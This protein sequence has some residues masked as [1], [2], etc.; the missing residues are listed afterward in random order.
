MAENFNEQELQA[1]FNRHLPH[2]PLPPEFAERLKQQVLAE[3][4]NTLQAAPY[5]STVGEEAGFGAAIPTSERPLQTYV[6]RD[7]NQRTAGSR[8]ERTAQ[9]GGIFAWLADRLRIAPSLA[10]AGATLAALWAL[11]LWGPALLKQFGDVM[12]PPQTS[13][14]GGQPA[15]IPTLPVASATATAT[16]T[17]TAGADGVEPT[18]ATANAV[19]LG[20]TS[21]VTATASTMP[22]STPVATEESA[23]VEPTVDVTDVEATD[24]AVTS[25]PTRGVPDILIPTDT[26][27][28][29][30]PS[31]VGNTPEATDTA[32][33]TASRTATA[34]MRSTNTPVS[35]SAPV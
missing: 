27:A 6:R 21:V 23:T 35:G 9:A 30:T 7:T 34:T 20:E 14:P 4:A 15:I 12:T 29:E 28:E 19:A 11:I 13:S 3:V 26:V 24:T 32:T 16:A 2:R 10:M 33:Q 18:D 31:S 22:T 25:T 5:Q 8:A 17:T 1:L